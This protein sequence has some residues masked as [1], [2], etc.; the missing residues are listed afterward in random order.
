MASVTGFQQHFQVEQVNS[1]CVLPLYHV[2][3]LMQ[4]MRSFLS[5]GKLAIVPFKSLQAG[6]FPALP[7]EHFFLSLVPTQL[8]R[9]LKAEE[10]KAQESTGTRNHERI[11]AA[12]LSSPSPS[13]PFTI[14]LG[15]ALAWAELLEA[16]RYHH[17][18]IAPTYGMTETAAQIAT[19]TPAEFL[20]GRSGCGRVLPHAQVTIRDE[21]GKKLAPHQVGRVAIAAKSLML[22]YFPQVSTQPE[23]LTEDLGF[24]DAAGY[25]H[26][27]GRA[28]GTIISG[29]ENVF[30]A[31]VEAAIWQT[32][33]VNDVCVIGLA[34]S[35]WGQV[36]TA[37][38]VPAQGV[39]V[40]ALKAA[41]ASNLCRYKQPK[42]WVA[43]AE[44][45]RNAQ[46]KINRQ[47]V[48]ALLVEQFRNL[49]TMSA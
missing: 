33:L 17:L 39:T 45:P 1:L 49:P 31:E 43:V 4:F 23:F 19:L 22:G 46:G 6:E 35:E 12:L 40:A 44:L 5:G 27:L 21:L 24:F 18:P 8:Q 7:A 47:Q 34:D 41:I 3:G 36:V 25:L 20:Q 2:S 10:M 32:G 26:I 16:A 38:Y 11:L 42:H 28:D 13:L 29:G 15:G 9:L 37:V 48:L 30:P 14:L